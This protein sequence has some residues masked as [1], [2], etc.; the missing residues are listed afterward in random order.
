MNTMPNEKARSIQQTVVLAMEFHHET[1]IIYL[2][3]GQVL[4]FIGFIHYWNEETDEVR[5]INQFDDIV[6]IQLNEI[7]IL[8]VLDNHD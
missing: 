4:H 2:Q 8:Y 5:I 1:S 6:R 7:V 3:N